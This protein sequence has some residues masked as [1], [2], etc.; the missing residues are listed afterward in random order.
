MKNTRAAFGYYRMKE[1]KEIE[2][3]ERIIIERDWNMFSLLINSAVLD[4]AGMY[5]CILTN[6]AGTAKCSA[7][8]I[9]ESKSK[10]NR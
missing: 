4:D 8:L 2:S 7:E 1:G 3:T 10:S 6:S 9:I 5:D